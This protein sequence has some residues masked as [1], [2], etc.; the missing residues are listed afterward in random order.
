M[1]QTV[2]TRTHYA[3][4]RLVLDASKKGKPV[5]RLTSF[6]F[7]GLMVA[8]A[9]SAASDYSATIAKPIDRRTDIFVEGNL[10]RCEGTTCKIVSKPIDADSVRT[11]HKLAVKVGEVTAYGSA[12]T[13]FSADQLAKCNGK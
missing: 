13:P 6:V 2:T 12:E 11:C 9:A 4:L 1:H 3:A 5:I 10:F 8:T 7:A